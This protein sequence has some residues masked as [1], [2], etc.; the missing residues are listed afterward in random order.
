M[1]D[2]TIILTLFDKL[3]RIDR[4]HKVHTILARSPWEGLYPNSSLLA[5]HDRK[6]YL[7][8]RQYVA[9]FPPRTL[10]FCSFSAVPE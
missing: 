5:D 3:V 8:M 9:E 1:S 10:L 2:G 7:G 4:N 6:L